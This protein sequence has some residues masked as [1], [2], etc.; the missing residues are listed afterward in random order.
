[1]LV[2][3]PAVE[4]SSLPFGQSRSPSQ[5]Q[6]RGTQAREPW[7][8][9]MSAAQVMAPENHQKKKKKPLQSHTAGPLRK[10][11]YISNRW[12]TEECHWQGRDWSFLGITTYYLPLWILPTQN[13]FIPNGSGNSVAKL[14]PT[15]CY[16]M[17]CSPPG[18]SVHG[19]LPARILEW[20]TISSFR[21]SSWPR[22][23]TGFSW[24]S[25]IGRWVL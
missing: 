3:Q 15:H 11:I 8:L 24:V 21:G 6:C 14:C 19:I 2:P 13:A 16:P 4:S 9:N 23:Q 7:Q 10:I 1:M 17:G 12:E 22:N 18:S 20:D 5:S 25:C